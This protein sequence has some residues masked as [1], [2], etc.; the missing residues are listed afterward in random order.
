MFKASTAPANIFSAVAKNIAVLGIGFGLL[1]VSVDYKKAAER[2]RLR[3]R[4]RVVQ[5]EKH[6]KLGVLANSGPSGQS[7]GCNLFPHEF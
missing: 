7:Q 2:V 1:G 5:N 6:V 3:L 4:L